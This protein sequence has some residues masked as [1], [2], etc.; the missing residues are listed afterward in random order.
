MLILILSVKI[1]IKCNV[2]AVTLETW[3]N[4]LAVDD[5][6]SSGTN[7]AVRSSE[8]IKGS[9][10]THNHAYVTQGGGAGPVGTHRKALSYRN[11]V[12]RFL[13]KSVP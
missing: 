11:Y 7:D 12:I 9:V 8:T 5:V 3:L 2:S 4:G 6:I 10:Y 1:R 13:A